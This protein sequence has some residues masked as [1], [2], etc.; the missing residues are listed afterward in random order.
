MRVSRPMFRLLT[1]WLLEGLPTLEEF[2]QLTL[3]KRDLA[4]LSSFRFV[5]FSSRFAN[6]PGAFVKTSKHRS[7]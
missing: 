3:K 2:P 6:T 5:H 7:W 1:I 4:A